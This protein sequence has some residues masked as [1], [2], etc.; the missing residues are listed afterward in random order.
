MP[1][2]PPQAVD[3]WSPDAPETR[4]EIAIAGRIIR[5]RKFFANQAPHDEFEEHHTEHAAATEFSRILNEATERGW[6]LFPE[7]KPN[8]EILAPG[9]VFSI[10]TPAESLWHVLTENW[11]SGLL[12]PDCLEASAV[13]F[14]FFAI[15][16]SEA[17][18]APL[19]PELVSKLRTCGATTVQLWEGSAQFL[20]A[21]ATTGLPGIGRLVIDTPWQTETRQSAIRLGNVSHALEAMPDLVDAVVRG[22]FSLTSIHHS[23]LETLELM[24]NP[25]PPTVVEG[26]IKSDLPALHTL[27][28]HLATE[29]AHKPAALAAVGKLLAS[30]ALPSLRALSIT[31]CGAAESFLDA[32]LSNLPRK[33]LER[34]RCGDLALDPDV[35]RDRLQAAAL[36]G[37]EIEIESD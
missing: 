1:P 17:E 21:I 19:F 34:L 22:I 33:G 14:Y 23:R 18:E 15:R 13:G 35:V 8:P 9:T 27:S 6:Q 3:I 20:A 10:P 28:I 11:K 5:R 37:I 25:L 16:N 4:R 36:H 31:G 12:S 2:L 7:R 24:S 29:A 30:K 26:L 32:V